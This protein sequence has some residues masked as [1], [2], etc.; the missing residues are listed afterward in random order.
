[1]A[2]SGLDPASFGAR[3]PSSLSHGERRRVAWAGL[4]ALEARIW[5][6][7]EP[8]SG[9]DAEGILVLRNAIV[10]QLE[11]GGSVLMINQD[12]R[13]RNWTSRILRLEG[14]RLTRLE[15]PTDPAPKAYDY[16]KSSLFA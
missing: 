11:K 9:L 12:P 1:L 13:L 8:T 4:A 7:D 14:G 6:L 10:R 5:L 16:P 15:T 2:E 3:P